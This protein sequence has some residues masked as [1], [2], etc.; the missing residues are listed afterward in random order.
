VSLQDLG[1][2]GEL[3][4]AIAV[5]ASLVYLAVQIRQNTRT[6][7][8]STYQGLFDHIADFQNLLL[9]NEKLGAIWSVGLSQPDSL[10]RGDQERF[11]LLMLRF[12]RQLETL[13]YEW[14][15]GLLDETLFRGWIHDSLRFAKQPGGESWWHANRSIFGTEFQAWWEST[16]S[17]R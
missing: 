13:H 16:M 7:K 8:T 1:N 10:S 5:V 9:A 17:A 12:F 11:G 2:I 15:E 3:V 6:V 4:G 14:R